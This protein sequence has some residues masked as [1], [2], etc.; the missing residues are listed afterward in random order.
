L[1]KIIVI[2]EGISGLVNLVL[3]LLYIKMGELWHFDARLELREAV[4]SLFS[5]KVLGAKIV[6]NKMTVEKIVTLAKSNC[7]LGNW[8]CRDPKKGS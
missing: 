1:F 3:R 7:R 5:L 2:D 8:L 4:A 6:L